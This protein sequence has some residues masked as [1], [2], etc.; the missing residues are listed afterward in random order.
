MYAQQFFLAGGVIALIPAL[1]RTAVANEMLGGGNHLP[2][3]QELSGTGNALQTFHHGTGEGAHNLRIFGKPLVSATPA[4]VPDDGQGWRERPVDARA[5]RGDFSG[6]GGSDIPDQAWIPGRAKADIV[7]EDRRA[8]SVVVAVDR[9][10]A[11]DDGN[12]H[13]ACPVVHGGV[14]KAVGQR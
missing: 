11:P 7:G 8:E 10:S 13:A 2:G 9:V 4:V 1:L 14:I 3:G 12:G 6:R 5:R